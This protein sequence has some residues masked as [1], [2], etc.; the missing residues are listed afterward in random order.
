T[1]PPPAAAA[2]AAP[3]GRAT[4]GRPAAVL[5]ALDAVQSREAAHIERLGG[6]GQEP[7]ATFLARGDAEEMRAE[8]SWL[9]SNR[10]LLLGTP[11]A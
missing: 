9:R 10:T 6:R 4:A 5:D 11:D 1:R 7:W 8:R 3:W 2:G